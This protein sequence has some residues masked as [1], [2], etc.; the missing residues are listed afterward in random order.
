MHRCIIGQPCAAD[1]IVNDLSREDVPAW[2]TALSRRVLLNEGVPE[3]PVLWWG[4]LDA[5]LMGLG[6]TEAHNRTI[7]CAFDADQPEV[8]QRRVLLHELAH[9]VLASRRGEFQDATY[10]LLVGF[11]DFL[12]DGHGHAF[13]MTA[14]RLYAEYLEPDYWTEATRRE[15]SYQPLTATSYTMEEVTP[16]APT[17]IRL[18]ARMKEAA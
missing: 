11:D 17:P 9:W 3:Q 2:A 4:T 10:G 15:H 5:G 12:T 13:Y 14:F 1:G 16:T 6:V 18:P 7:T 8:E